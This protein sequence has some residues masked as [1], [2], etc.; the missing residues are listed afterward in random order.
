M[1]CAGSRSPFPAPRVEDACQGD[2]GGP[3]TV[4]GKLA[5]IVSFGED[6]GRFPGVYTEVNDPGTRPLLEDDSQAAPP[7]AAGGPTVGGQARVGQTV[8]CNP[9]PSAGAV[10]TGYRWYA[11]TRSAATQIGSSRS[12]QVPSSAE[13]SAI[14]CDARLEGSESGFAYSTAGQVTAPVTGV[15][16]QGGVAPSPGA[17]QPRRLSDVG[18]GGFPGR[19]T[20]LRRVLRRGLAGRVSCDADCSFR[21]ELVLPR[22]SARRAHVRG[23]VAVVSRVR[24]GDRAGGSGRG[25]RFRFSHR[26]ATKLRRLTRGTAI[27]VRVTASD[28]GGTHRTEKK[29]L[30]LRR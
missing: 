8:T 1:L 30:R 14:F 10:A 20:S 18:F 19:R 6:C 15:A 3:L 21:A 26:A 5:G 9:R 24:S 16:E 4:S 25:I 11:G 2:S 17:Q 27:E 23:R 28:S 29:K 13:G 7:T 22:R 12:I